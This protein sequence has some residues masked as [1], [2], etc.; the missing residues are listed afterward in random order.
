[1]KITALQRRNYSFFILMITLTDR[2]I[3]TLPPST[4]LGKAIPSD[5]LTLPV[6]ILLKI[7]ISSQTL[8]EDIFSICGSSGKS[9]EEKPLKDAKKTGAD[10]YELQFSK[11]PHDIKDITIKIQDKDKRDDRIDKEKVS[12]EE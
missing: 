11:V 2:L 8:P 3:I 5:T 10:Q 7:K 12:L 9:F 1:M 6:G 4:A